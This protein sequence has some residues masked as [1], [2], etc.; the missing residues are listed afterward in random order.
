[1]SNLFCKVHVGTTRHSPNSAFFLL[2]GLPYMTNAGHT[3]MTCGERGHKSMTS[4]K[5]DFNKQ[6]NHEQANTLL[7][8]WCGGKDHLLRTSSKCKSPLRKRT[9]Q[10]PPIGP[11]A[12]GQFFKAKHGGSLKKSLNKV[13]RSPALKEKLSAIVQAMTAVQYDATRLLNFYMLC[14][15]QIDLDVPKINKTFIRKF[16]SIVQKHPDQVSDGI[17]ANFR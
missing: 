6:R 1:M 14:M 7:C 3:C 5:C 13:I 15:V 2:L 12:E 8:E 10:T 17:H 16:F 11:L 4:K 9:S